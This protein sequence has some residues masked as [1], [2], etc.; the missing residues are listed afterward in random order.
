[1]RKPLESS[2]EHQE[3]KLTQ[4]RKSQKREWYG[5]PSKSEPDASLLEKGSEK[6]IVGFSFGL[7]LVVTLNPEEDRRG[8][9]KELMAHLLGS[10]IFLRIQ[11]QK[12]AEMLQDAPSQEIDFLY[13][14]AANSLLL[15]TFLCKLRGPFYFENDDFTVDKHVFGKEI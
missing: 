5:N 1:M 14:F 9:S 10:F 8:S 2:I 6:G 4:P 12:F 11:S 15:Y 13:L 7:E 3:I